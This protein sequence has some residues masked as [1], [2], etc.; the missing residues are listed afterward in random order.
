MA[1]T[2]KNKTLEVAEKAHKRAVKTSQQV[3]TSEVPSKMGQTK[4]IV[5]NE[6]TD[7]EYTIVLRFPGV[8][9]ASQLRDNCMNPFGFI[10][11]TS[12]MQEAI[13]PNTG[14]IAQPQVKSLSFWDDHDGYD[15]VCDEAISF[16]ANLL[17]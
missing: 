8:V 11:R 9:A 14:L 17:N 13:K 5:I 4:E 10:N 2:K 1:A 7:K 6:G 12:F 15:Q 16:L 3:R